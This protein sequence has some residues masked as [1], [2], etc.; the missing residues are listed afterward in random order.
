MRLPYA[1]ALSAD[2]ATARL[3]ADYLFWFVPALS[4]Q[5]LMVVMGAALRGTGNFKPGMVVQTATVIVNMLLAPFLMFGWLTGR[6]LGVAGT[7]LATFISVAIGS[8]WLSLYFVP[9]QAYLKFVV[10]DW[11]P[12]LELWAN[13]LRIGLPAGAEFALMGVYLFV[14]YA[15][16]RP[17]GAA[18]QAGFGIGMR[19]IQAG[20]MPVVA[21]GFAVAPVAG[22]N[23]GARHA[24]RVRE[25]FR[26]AVAM[27]AGTMLVLVVACHVIPEAMVRV[28]SSDPRVIAVGVEYLRIV[29]WNFVASGIVFVGSSMFQAMGNTLPALASSLVRVLVVVLPAVALSRHPGFELRWIWWL[30]VVSTTLQMA[31]SLLL[32]RREFRRRLEFEAAPVL[33]EAT[34]ATP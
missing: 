20:F 13:L 4:L 22:Q 32:L 1:R 2:L 33:R 29:S 27:A 28:F 26:V 21:L 5:F 14:V 3:A 7:A 9:R 31:I 18:A 19:V 23:F 25:T 24:D 8:A 12:R 17:F 10:A 11:K 6:P 30:T 15:L 34:P 16:S